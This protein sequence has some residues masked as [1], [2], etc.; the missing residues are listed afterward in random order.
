MLN[1][2]YFHI[3]D[4]LF[5]TNKKKSKDLVFWNTKKLFFFNYFSESIF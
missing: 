4:D 3:L 5:L 2:I 1:I